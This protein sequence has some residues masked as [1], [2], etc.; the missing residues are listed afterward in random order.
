MKKQSI[1]VELDGTSI[2]GTKA[3]ITSFGLFKNSTEDYICIGYDITKG[4]IWVNKENGNFATNEITDKINKVAN[5]RVNGKI[6]E[7]NSTIEKLNRLNFNRIK[8]N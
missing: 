6:N 5:R 7:L 2:I 8:S 3:K 4:G 1:S